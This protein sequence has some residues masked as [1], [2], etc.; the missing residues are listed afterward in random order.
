MDGHAAWFV[1]PQDALAKLPNKSS[2]LKL[3]RPHLGRPTA[4]VEEYTTNM[5]S[6]DI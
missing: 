4:T 6:R 1:Q 5:K 2:A 3:L